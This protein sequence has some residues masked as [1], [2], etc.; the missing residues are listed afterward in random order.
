VWRLAESMQRVGN[1]FSACCSFAN[2]LL[3]W[4]KTRQ[5]SGRSKASAVFFANLEKELFALK[6]ELTT[7]V[8]QPKPFHYFDVHD[9]KHRVIAVSDYRDR[10]VHHALVNVLEPTFEKTFIHDSYATRKGKGVHAAVFRAQHY[11]RGHAFY[12]KTDVE[13]FF[14][15]VNH[16][17]LLDILACK[18]KDPH[19]LALCATIIRHGTH[20]QLPDENGCLNPIGLPIGNR[21]S[22][23]FANVYLDP[24][25]HFIK[26]HCSVHGYVRYMDDFVLFEHD[27]A[28]LKILQGMV[29]TFLWEKLQL[30]LKPASTFMNRRENG[31]PF[32][33][34]RIFSGIVRLRSENLRRITRRIALRERA[35]LQG[36][37]DEAS[38]LHS[39]NSYW[40]MLSYYPE[41]APLRNAILLKK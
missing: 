1:L 23:F 20:T 30:R 13:K 7:G 34:R 15:S 2:L 35:L 25:D 22:Q 17:I 11:M 24:L 27:N 4:R 40:A 19:I 6:D 33:G 16:R 14:D 8:W 39:M 28:R 38:F 41:C 37:L 32:L 21:T 10:V 26:D 3:A 18:I 31:L 5:G 9:P 29:Q 12:F 36:E